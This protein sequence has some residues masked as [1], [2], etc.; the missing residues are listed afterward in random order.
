MSPRIQSSLPK[1]GG[2]AGSGGGEASS[3][4]TIRPALRA[5]RDRPGDLPE[6][7]TDRVVRVV[8]DSHLHL[9]DMFE[10]TFHEPDIA[11]TA[12]DER[13][14]QPGC[15]VELLA[16]ATDGGASGTVLVTGEITSV[17][18]VCQDMTVHTV[19]RGFDPSHR[20]HR[21]RSTRTFLN[22]TDGQIAQQ[23]AADAGLPVGDVDMS[24]TRYAHVSQVAETDWE[25]LR[26]RARARGWE[27]GVRD[28]KFHF[29]PPSGKAGGLLSGGSSGPV[30]LTFGDNLL[31]FRPRLTPSGPARE[32]EVRAW[33]AHSGKAVSSRADVRDSRDGPTGAAVTSTFD[34]PS[35]P[36]NQRRA[37]KPD[38]LDV[39][40]GATAV[41]AAAAQGL[42]E[43]AKGL[44]TRL[45][46]ARGEAEGRL[47]GHPGVRAGVEV[48][49]DGV[50]KAFAGR[51]RVSQ[52][53]HV[54]G[55]QEG[56]RTRFTA[57]GSEDRSL[58]GL[59]AGASRRERPAVEGVVCA[60]VSDI[61]DP[62][63]RGRVRL[64]LPWL[65]EDYESDWARVA[66]FSGGDRGGALFLPGVGDEVLVGFELGDPERPVVLGSLVNPRSKYVEK[67]LGGPALQKKGKTAEVARRGFVSDTGNML[68]FT[69]GGAQATSQVTLA[70]AQGN[71]AL[72]IDQRAH[73]VTLKC[74]A[75]P[76]G[77][78][79]QRK[80]TVQCDGGAVTVDAG[81]TGTVSVKAGVKGRVLVE[82]GEIA[83]S[84]DRKLSL[85]SKGQLDIKGTVV[86]VSGTP[87]K[88][89]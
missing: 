22:S 81:A 60:V 57:G 88:L 64:H 80:L 87:I 24:G 36:S 63:G 65:A 26:R 10:I 32:V 8:V 27:T 49:V 73:S 42:A 37:S 66:Q 14:L 11:A 86:K 47:M 34:H 48:E 44:A 4:F 23:V 29:G 2:R 54:F 55:E 85:T 30:T 70:N 6:A 53:Q 19:V 76:S 78:D 62:T 82:G 3:P 17:E 25:F 74:D 20:L 7:L 46:G 43:R 79:G 68:V 1:G 16:A 40:T 71:M 58:Y 51:W 83:V 39:V 35:T 28:G 33:D 50:P 61:N 31:A 18:A 5:G 72:V 56:Y 77:R 52:A 15:K 41:G 59:A 75:A 13:A 84:A 45:A 38:R 12:A 21:G 67:G 69:D 9:P 89:N